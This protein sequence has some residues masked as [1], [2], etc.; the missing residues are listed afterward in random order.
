MF[1]HRLDSLAVARAL[2]WIDI[3]RLPAANICQPASQSSNL[4][5]PF[6]GTS[7]RSQHDRQ[8]FEGPVIGKG[9]QLWG[10][11]LVKK[12]FR[13]EEH[14]RTRICK[15]QLVF[16]A[17]RFVFIENQYFSS[18]FPSSSPECSGH[19]DPREALGKDIGRR[20]VQTL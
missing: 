10:H 7:C 15:S 11:L 4:N 18:D 1:D 13:N 3:R 5:V 14:P 2:L 20:L 8:C 6:F 19:R 9:C 16:S 12:C 17:C